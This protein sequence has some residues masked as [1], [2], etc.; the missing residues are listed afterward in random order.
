MIQPLSVC[1]PGFV[2]GARHR[3]TLETP[4]QT[5]DRTGSTR[6]AQSRNYVDAAFVHKVLDVL[7]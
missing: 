6:T 3:A 5:S 7:Q 4:R 1:A 2:I